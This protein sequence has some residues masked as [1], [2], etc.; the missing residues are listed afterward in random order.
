MF[1]QSKSAKRRFNNG[2][3]H[4]KYFKGKGIDIGA[5]PDGI[6]NIKHVFLGIENV[7]EWDISNGDGQYL[8]NVPD[9]FFDFVHSSHSLEHMNDCKIALENWIRVC[10][11]GGFII[12]T[13]PEE[14]M[15]EKN[16]WP[17]KFNPDH[18]W[19]FTLRNDSKMPKT[20]NVLDLAKQFNNKATVEKI[21]YVDEFYNANKHEIDQT[22]LPNAEC[23]IEIIFKKI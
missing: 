12:I 8:E 3:F 17:S 10:K 1:E 5:G 7:L 16:Y 23:C 15:Y 2:N 11:S 4:V 21:E 18:K 14:Y 20:I 9:N 22:M 13:V 19:S 6:S